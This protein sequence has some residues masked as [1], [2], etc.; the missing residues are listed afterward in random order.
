MDDGLY[1]SLCFY[2][3]VLRCASG[4][5]IMTARENIMN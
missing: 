1:E 4:F 2:V 5:F 3:C